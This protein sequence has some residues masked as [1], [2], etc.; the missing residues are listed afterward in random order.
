MPKPQPL[1]AEHSTGSS[2][3]WHVDYD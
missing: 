1:L 2:S 3:Y